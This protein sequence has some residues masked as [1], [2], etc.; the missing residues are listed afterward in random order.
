MAYWPALAVGSAAQF[1][2]LVCAILITGSCVW[3]FW[4]NHIVEV[5][6][7]GNKKW[8]KN[9]KKPGGKKSKKKGG[10]AVK[11]APPVKKTSVA[12]NVNVP[13]TAASTSSLASSTADVVEKDRRTVTSPTDS[14]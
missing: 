3:C 12:N 5:P 6:V 13:S 7:S 14:V 4:Q 1:K 11:G 9:K 10:G 2:P 8:M